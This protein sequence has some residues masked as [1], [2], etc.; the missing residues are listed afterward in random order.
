LESLRP[1]TGNA[2]KINTVRGQYAAGE[3]DG[4]AVPS[5]QEELGSPSSTETYVAIRAHIDNSRWANVPFYLRTGKRM[6]QRFAEIVIQYKDVAHR[7]YPESAGQ[8][9][10]NRLVIRLQPEE[11]IKIIMTSKNLEK[12]EAELR[13][14]VLNFNFADTYKDFYSDAYKR[15]ML[16]AAANDPS[17]FIH[18]AEVA[19][20]WGWID[21]IIDAW[22]RPENN[23]Q[24]YKSGGWGPRGADELIQA[25]G[26]HWFVIDELFAAKDEV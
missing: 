14:V 23:P 16:D 21:S 1:L 18:R 5:Y 3:I 26:R 25:D 2:V 12:H 15:L 11:S 9:V 10:P 7:V 8:T 13:P 20:A 6:K 4:K 22:E 19:A 24:F 17:L